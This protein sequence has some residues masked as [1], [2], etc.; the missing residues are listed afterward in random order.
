MHTPKSVVCLNCSMTVVCQMSEFGHT[1]LLS[2]CFSHTINYDIL[3]VLFSAYYEFKRIV[4]RI[5]YIQTY[6][7]FFILFSASYSFVYSFFLHTMNSDIL[8]FCHP[9]FSR[10]ATVISDIIFFCRTVLFH[11]V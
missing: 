11:E 3:L 2:S 4:L 10:T 8:L 6:Y 1:T 7:S 9:F 5:L